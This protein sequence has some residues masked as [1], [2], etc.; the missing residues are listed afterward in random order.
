MVAITRLITSSL[1]IISINF[2]IRSECLNW[3]YLLLV[4]GCT[5][6]LWCNN[7]S[8]DEDNTHVLLGATNT[9]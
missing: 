8:L 9:L 2:F 5:S 3:F 6:L 4:H 7:S 1:V